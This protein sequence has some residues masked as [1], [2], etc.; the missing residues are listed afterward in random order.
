MTTNCRLV[1]GLKI[2]GI[3]IA[4]PVALCS[5]LLHNLAI[6]AVYTVHTERLYTCMSSMLVR[7]LAQITSYVDG[8][9]P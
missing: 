2:D 6:V 1:R 4:F 5:L 9:F 8:V 7:F 3:V